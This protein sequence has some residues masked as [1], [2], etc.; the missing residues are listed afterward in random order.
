MRSSWIRQSFVQSTFALWIGCGGC[1]DTR[2]TASTTLAAMSGAPA[3]QQPMQPMQPP[4]M[5][6]VTD[7]NAGSGGAPATETPSGRPSVGVTPLPCGIADVVRLR[8][9]AATRASRGCS[10]RWRSSRKRTSWRPRSATL[11][12]ACARWP[13]SA[14]TT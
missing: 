7:G 4:A 6:D 10:R 13:P 3:A 12:A 8:A 1:A 5:G 14:S 9:R 11:H 2:D